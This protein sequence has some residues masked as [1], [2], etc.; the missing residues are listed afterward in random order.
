M[1]TISYKGLGNH[2][3]GA[4]LDQD[5]EWI[6]YCNSLDEDASFYKM[7]KDMST[8]IKL[9]DRKVSNIIFITTL[10]IFPKIHLF[11][12]LIKMDVIYNK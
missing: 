3:N 9:Y 11:S 7:K 10:F 4:Y 2:F 8:Q 12:K 6:Y 1:T 5:K